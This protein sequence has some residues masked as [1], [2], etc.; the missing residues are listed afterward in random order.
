MERKDVCGSS[1]KSW[2]LQF[3]CLWSEWRSQSWSVASGGPQNEKF[4][5][6]NTFKLALGMPWSSPMDFFVSDAMLWGMCSVL[7]ESFWQGCGCFGILGRSITPLEYNCPCFLWLHSWVVPMDLNRRIGSREQL[8]CLPPAL[9]HT[10]WVST[11]VWGFNS[12]LPS[13]LQH[14]WQCSRSGWMGHSVT[15][16]GQRNYCTW[17][18]GW[19]Q[20]IFM[21]PSTQII[22]GFYDS[23]TY[24]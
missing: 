18:W 22:L 10:A 12:W 17:Q 21:T 20:V 6:L 4:M 16:S 9:Q 5:E 11:G 14:P 2:W 3:P 19:N 8:L 15:W 7:M 24:N 23:K 1:T 13:P